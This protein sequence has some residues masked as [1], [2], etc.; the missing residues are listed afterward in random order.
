M[1]PILHCGWLA[2]T[3]SPKRMRQ[4]YDFA[5]VCAW[6]NAVMALLSIRLVSDK[7]R[8]EQS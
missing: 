5:A 4:T 1:H 7:Y 2:N 8:D 3:K 6:P